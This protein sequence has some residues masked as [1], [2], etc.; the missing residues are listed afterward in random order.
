MAKEVNLFGNAS[1]DSREI[2]TIGSKPVGLQ[3]YKNAM[4]QPL[5]E[6]SLPSVVEEV[7]HT[8]PY[9]GLSTVVPKIYGEG[10]FMQSTADNIF[11]QDGVQIF[12]INT[13]PIQ[14]GRK[15]Y[16]LLN[17]I[18]T[19]YGKKEFISYISRSPIDSEKG[20]EA[21][22]DFSNLSALSRKADLLLTDDAKKKYKFINPYALG[23]PAMHKGHLYRGF[24]MPFVDGY[25]ELRADVL[26]GKRGAN[27][28]F[29]RYSIPY[30]RE[31]ED[32]NRRSYNVAHR[33]V[34][35]SIL[36]FKTLT[37]EHQG[38]LLKR[39]METDEAK[40]ILKQKDDVLVGN[41]LIYLLSDG[42]FP[43]EFQINAGDWM[44]D[45]V[46]DKLRL[47]LITVRGGFKKVQSDEE[48]VQLMSSHTE[49]L[50]GSEST[51]LSFPPF[52]AIEGQI[53]K[54]LI[55]A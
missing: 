20:D 41:A 53:R 43:K 13:M 9:E 18:D 5:I 30:T 19:D 35:N 50:P 27:T 6:S 47:C 3:W 29:F 51:G 12:S 15:A 44:A 28:A 21:A 34:N 38:I 1:V 45:F 26:A 10:N 37:S 33:L 14:M 42:H 4:I 7:S 23:E 8:L 55:K 2:L 22:T 32:Q 16:I 31:M 46:M 36:D 39:L 48:W 49:P 17:E 24:S 11:G 54:A 25:G 52:Y 40:I